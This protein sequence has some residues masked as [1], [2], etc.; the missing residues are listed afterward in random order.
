MNKQQLQESLPWYVNDTL[1][2]AEK[3]E[4]ETALAEHPEL[5]QEVAFLQTLQSAVKQQQPG[6]Q[7]SVRSVATQHHC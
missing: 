5:Q 7:G 4:V 3:Q 2:D 6:S 1:T